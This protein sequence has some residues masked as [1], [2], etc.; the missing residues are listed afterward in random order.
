[1]SQYNINSVNT[2]HIHNPKPSHPYFEV[3]PHSQ[4]DKA[5]AITAYLDGT[6]GVVQELI[7]NE[8]NRPLHS[9]L[10][11]INLNLDTVRDMINQPVAR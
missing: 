2:L 7:S 11:L 9:L 3:K 10:Y 6:I 8:E 4:I 1:M 5:D